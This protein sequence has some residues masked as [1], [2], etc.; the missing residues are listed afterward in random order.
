MD[1]TFSAD[2]QY[3]SRI[4]RLNHTHSRKNLRIEQREKSEIVSRNNN[5]V[6]I[7]STLKSK[8]EK[9]K[10]EASKNALINKPVRTL[11]QV[12]K[13]AMVRNLFSYK[14]KYRQLDLKNQARQTPDLAKVKMTETPN[15]TSK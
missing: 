10:A 14:L 6:D 8:N 12:F 13:E 15:L 4:H 5:N 9:R 3:N 2:Q 11:M 1:S 7:T